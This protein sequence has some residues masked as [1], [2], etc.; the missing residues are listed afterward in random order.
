[1]I[2][3]NSTFM[4]S[5]I[6]AMLATCYLFGAGGAIRVAG[7]DARTGK[8]ASLFPRDFAPT[9]G[10]IK[11]QEH[12]Y[13]DAVCLNGSWK[14]MPIEGM[15]SLKGRSGRA[16]ALSGDSLLRAE[17]PVDPSWEKVA[18]KVPSP[19]NV[20]GFA[21]GGRGGD[22]IT[23]PGYPKKWDTVRAGWLMRKLPYNAAWKDKRLILH[24]DAVAG[25]AIIFVNKKEVGRHFDIFLPFDLD[26]TD[27]INKDGDNELLVWIAG[28]DLFNEPGEYGRRVY[29]G[30]SF[31]GQYIIGIWQD[32]WLSVRPPVYVSNLFVQPFVSRDELR[33]EVTVRNETGATREYRVSGNV[34][35]WINLAGNSVL[36]APEPTWKLG[37][38]ALAIGGE[39]LK[40]AAHAEKKITLT[41]RVNGRLALWSPG[42]PNLY[43]MIIRL[44]G[45]NGTMDRK[46]DRFGW[47]E[48]KIEGSK[49]NLN[50]QPIVLKGDSWHFMGIP[51]MTRRY[52]W[53]WYTMLKEAGANAVRLH[54]E[55]YPA[56]FPDMADEMGMMVLDETG[57]W[58]SDGGPK[59]DAETYWQNAE[60]HLRNFIIRDR[61]HPSVLG[62]SV[63]N[64]NIPVAVNVWHAPESLVEKQLS[65]I[66]RWV[67]TAR[68]LDPTRNWISGDG[69]TGRPT[70]LPTLIGHYGDEHDY[71][72]WS[73]RGKLWGIG[74]SGMAYYGTP[75]QSSVYN[76]DES[77]VSQE[78]RMRGVAEEATRILDLQKKY[79]AS[80]RSVFNLVW[81]GLK[82]L[83]L[84]LSDTGRAPEA[85][86]G[87]FFKPFREGEPGV[88]PERLGPYTSTLNPGY[89]PSLPLYRTWPL[90]DAIRA[91]FSDTEA[92]AGDAGKRQAASD[93]PKAIFSAVTLLSADKDSV[94]YAVLKDMGIAVSEDR[95]AD[96]SRLVVI[97]G[98][99]PP[100]DEASLAVAGS[101]LDS[102]GILLI[103]GAGPSAAGINKYLPEPVTLTD[104]KASSFIVAPGEG[105]GADAEGAAGSG[106]GAD[107][108]NRANI[109]R[110]LGNADLYFSELSRLP[111][112]RYCLSGD[113]V[114]KGKVLLTACNTDW[115]SWNDQPEWRKTI[116]VIRSERETKPEGN[117]LVE[118]P[119]RRG[120]I[121]FLSLDPS[122]LYKT[123]ENVL[124]RLFGN[125][126]MA[127]SGGGKNLEALDEA[128]LLRHAQVL[129]A[130]DGTHLL[131]SSE[132]AVFDVESRPGGVAYISFW[133]Y[134]PRSLVN[135]LAEPDLPVLDMEI[136]DMR[137]GVRG[138]GL[139]AG[140]EGFRIFLNGKPVGNKVLPVEKGWNQFSICL[141]QP[142]HQK[143]MVKFESGNR[144]FFRDIRSRV[145]P[146]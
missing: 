12:P 13:R 42:H 43:A 39:R 20:N 98:S 91:G 125:V 56:F 18:V 79:R 131:E 50:G 135:L 59:I 35:S 88:Q 141:S 137:K 3:I 30:G 82:P 87:I 19:W 93:K 24:F 100:G 52:A 143:L 61:D 26:I 110:G 120:R 90:F 78:G 139:P 60:D 27:K 22:F 123:S 69:E 124:Q 31:W 41:S 108:G 116:A 130:A 57:L 65:Q 8:G 25:Y 107:K 51:Q 104:R 54:A 47:R 67:A 105:V 55:P 115:N 102:G 5:W 32:V 53:A 75:R 140:K 86:D 114:R 106:V 133:L 49:L 144:D 142:G 66:D 58:A 119:A 113:F 136:L 70:E 118:Y 33:V 37:A 16:G 127:F 138:A 92:A 134:S 73:S 11:P 71:Q 34:L 64:E 117:A 48:F 68:E 62:W 36:D 10:L 7:Q 46:V 85:S 81:Y 28:A 14:F 83:E 126:G 63:C 89:D 95:R 23:Y 1:M 128:G 121:Y 9:E 2:L 74:E 111:V 109:L 80:Y 99:Q 84:G 122:T 72:D 6:K 40:I 96:P 146:E 97:D 4:D 112:A 77:Y 129:G 103:L 29:V 76:G 132:E 101:A 21:G 44:S 45:V 17:L 38:E 145:L 15:G 94:L